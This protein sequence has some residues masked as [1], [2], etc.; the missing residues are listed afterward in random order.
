MADNTPEKEYL[1]DLILEVMQTNETSARIEQSSVQMNGYLNDINANAYSSF[2]VLNDIATI[3]S[4]N[5]LAALEKSRED[6]K[7][8]QR[9]IDALEDVRD[10]TKK[11]KGVKDLSGGGIAGLGGIL[12]FV[13]GFIKG[14]L[15]QF[16]KVAKA[17]FEIVKAT[18]STVW[19]G[20]KATFK[21]IRTELGAS[22]LGKAFASLLAGI[23]MQID[24]L[25]DSIKTYFKGQSG[26][27]MTKVKAAWS[28]VKNFFTG[29]GPSFM[30]QLDGWK[31]EFKIFK[32]FL[33]PTVT[34]VKGLL[35]PL[36]DLG[37]R[38]DDIKGVFS[39]I[40]D[41]IVG[42][43]K[44]VFAKIKNVLGILGGGDSLLG[45]VGSIFGKFLAPV[46]F[47]LTLWDTVKG[48]YEGYQDG[49]IF[50]AIKGALT[51]FLGSLVGEPLN[52]LKSAVSWIAEKLG[53]GAVSEVLDSFDFMKF[54][55]SGISGIFDWV[56]LIFTDPGAALSTLWNNLVGEG[57]LMDLLFKPIDMLIDWVREKFGFKA[58]GEDSF[59]IGNL[60][61]G[62]WNGIIDG[63]ASFVEGISWVPNSAADKIRE[64]KAGT[65]TANLSE[66]GAVDVEKAAEGNASGD[67]LNAATADKRNTET[68]GQMV[69]DTAVMSAGEAAMSGGGGGSSGPQS[70]T[71]TVMN[72]SNGKLPDRTDWTVGSG[73][74]VAP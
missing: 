54:I 12:A 73:W 19:K 61:R 24:L 29:I 32:D 42:W 70:T 13:G 40:K 14:Y 68:A 45:R 56:T 22:R 26:T 36:L 50:G 31:D 1:Q 62:L 15:V 16:T 38:V 60:V 9:M 4:G 49:G 44:G 2:E 52:M 37:A 64:L 10:N 17:F 18:I 33:G 25:K 11:D 67:A 43:V 63:V 8:Q 28:A 48:A 30:K 5:N 35:A 41:T 34:K 3:M 21:W 65:A 66:M 55:K 53:F 7:L 20:L 27:L 6:G 46:T 47:L 59:S 58:P 71:N 51:G 72:I 57:G 23:S 39:F 74:N 69:Q